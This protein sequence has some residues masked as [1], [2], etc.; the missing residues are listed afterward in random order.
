MKKIII[1]KK[2][3]NYT[4]YFYPFNDISNKEKNVFDLYLGYIEIKNG[5]N[6]ISKFEFDINDVY[7]EPKYTI[8]AIYRIPS[9]NYTEIFF[10]FVENLETFGNAKLS[11]KQKNGERYYEVNN[12]IFKFHFTNELFSYENN[13]IINESLINAFKEIKNIIKS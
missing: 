6:I 3:E 5:N 8:D 13:I 11:F 12:N 9:C 1:I 2:M 4:A 7:E 10:N